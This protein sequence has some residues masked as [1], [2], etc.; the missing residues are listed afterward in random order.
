MI[1]ISGQAVSQGVTNST[2]T[3]KWPSN[4]PVGIGTQ[5]DGGPWNALHIHYDSTDSLTRPAVLR[6]SQ[7]TST[8]TNASGILGLI[9]LTPV[10]SLRYS[11]LI[12]GQD[13]V[14]RANHGDLI[15]TDFWRSFG[16]SLG[17]AIRF[18]TSPDS[19]SLPLAV[20]DTDFERLTILSNGNVGIDLPPDSATGLGIPKDQLQIGGG[21]MPYPGNTYPNP[22]LSIY[23][24]NWYENRPRF[25]GGLFPGD[26]RYISY[27][28]WVDHTDTSSN[29]FHRSEPMSSSAVSFSE[30]AGGNI[31]LSC[32]PY[33]VMRGIDDF[34]H[35]LTMEVTG[36]GLQMWS[37]E[38]TSD[39]YHHL[40]DIFRP[41]YSYSWDSVRNVNGLCYLHTPVYIG[42]D[43]TDR[44]PNFTDFAHVNPTLGDGKTWMLAVNGPMVAKEI[45]VLDTVWADFVF[46]PE[47]KL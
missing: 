22:G 25:G 27:N 34:T 5:L 29:R 39:Q 18:A 23:G 15:L 19:A 37:Y 46:Q 2:G 9:P 12:R 14:L 24:G 6:F 30:N 21:V 8:N 7:A 35:S 28:R 43:T 3:Q 32:F 42:T 44:W 33:D 41:G 47:H 13:F 17:G 38:S 10:D 31:D 16:G 11:S 4:P 1:S 20:I 40:I 36:N 26:W 45:F